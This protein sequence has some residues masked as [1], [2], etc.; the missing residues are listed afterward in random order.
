MIIGATKVADVAGRDEEQ[1]RAPRLVTVEVGELGIAVIDGPA[2]GQSVDRRRPRRGSAGVDS[3]GR[4]GV[5]SVDGGAARSDREH[6]HAAPGG[7]L[8]LWAVDR[9]SSDS[10]VEITIVVGV[11]GQELHRLQ[12]VSQLDRLGVDE[13]GVQVSVEGQACH[14]SS[15]RLDGRGLPARVCDVQVRGSNRVGEQRVRV[16]HASV[17]DAHH[18][19]ILVGHP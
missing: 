15:V 2:E 14:L 16:L 12:A 5:S 19:S 11:I 7:G 13:C 10:T 17:E 18:R 4:F 9:A 6:E 1:A 3:C 8:D